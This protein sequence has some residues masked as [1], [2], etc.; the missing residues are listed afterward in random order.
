RRLARCRLD[1]DDHIA[2][3]VFAQ[4][5]LPLTLGERQHVGRAI[6][7]AKCP[8]QRPHLGVADQRDRQLAVRLAEQR[9]RAA[10]RLAHEPATLTE[11]PRRADLDRGAPRRQGTRSYALMIFC[12]SG[13]R[14]TSR[15]VK[16][17]KRIPS[18]PCRMSRASINPEALPWG[19]S[20]CVTS[21]VI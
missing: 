18:M 3:Q 19:R 6:L 17:T 16:V 5:P 11:A 14:T 10:R 9:E 4:H 20:I 7:R 15:S 2:E 12:T 1:R 21:P 13:W 8:V